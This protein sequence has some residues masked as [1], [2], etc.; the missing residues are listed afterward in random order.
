MTGRKAGAVRGPGVGTRR[1]SGSRLWGGAAPAA[2]ADFPATQPAL[3]HRGSGEDVRTEPW[4][5]S[6]LQVL[7]GDMD[8]E[9]GNCTGTVRPVISSRE[10]RLSS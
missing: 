1:R 3:R 4:A 5:V 6:S 7:R 2:L 9:G 8:R 10:S